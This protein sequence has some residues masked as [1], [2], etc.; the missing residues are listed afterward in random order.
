MNASDAS[1]MAARPPPMRRARRPTSAVEIPER[2]AGT[3]RM[4]QT[5]SPS[6]RL[7]PAKTKIDSGGWSTYPAARR[8]LQ[9]M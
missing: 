4:A 2:I 3:R 5:E 6:A 9:A 7:A 1:T 8:L